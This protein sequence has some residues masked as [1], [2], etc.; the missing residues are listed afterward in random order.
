MG[1][2]VG[3]ELLPQAHG[4]EHRRC[5]VVCARVLACYSPT[6]TSPSEAMRAV[7]WAS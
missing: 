6:G 7:R 3:V 4:G 5:T 1:R 2:D